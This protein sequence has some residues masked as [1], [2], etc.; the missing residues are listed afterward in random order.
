MKSATSV[1]GILALLRTGI[2]TGIESSWTE[3]LAWEHAGGDL[4]ASQRRSGDP[5]EAGHQRAEIW[6]VGARGGNDCL[7]FAPLRRREH[8]RASEFER[9]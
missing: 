3:L 9:G 2:T 8:E 4:A 6:G 5:G 1:T 7:D